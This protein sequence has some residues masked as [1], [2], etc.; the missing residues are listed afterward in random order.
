[1]RRKLALVARE[2]ET[3]A[4]LDVIDPNFPIVLAR[5]IKFERCWVVLKFPSP[6]LEYVCVCDIFNIAHA[7]I[8]YRKRLYQA[9]LS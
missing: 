3:L 4:P 7:T 9:E 8:V 6:A 1:M 2:W 5:I